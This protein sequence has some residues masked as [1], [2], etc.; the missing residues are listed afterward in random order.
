MRLRQVVQTLL[1]SASFGLVVVLLLL[2]TGSELKAQ[3]GGAGAQVRIR[4]K[5]V[6]LDGSELVVA[7]ANGNVK[8]K[9][10]DKTAIVG[11][12]PVKLSEIT[13]GKYLGTT[14]TKQPDGN[15]LASEVHIFPDDQRGVSEG[16]HPLSSAPKSGATMTN[17][18][19]ERV[20]EAAVQSL[21]GRIMTVK[22]KGGEVKVLI[23]P[24]IP[25]VKRVTGDRSSFKPGAELSVQGTRAADGSLS[26][27]EITVRAR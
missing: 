5:I 10:G 13:P 9:V 25:V 24:D 15:F 1:H 4:G 17:G 8:V 27:S 21:K 3:D 7:S 20:E 16:H 22:Y 14:A 2:V 19:V 12:V 18:N 6:S 23:P 26:A 11:E